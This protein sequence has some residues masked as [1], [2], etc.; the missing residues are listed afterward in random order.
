M[1]KL[2]KNNNFIGQGWKN[3]SK[4]IKFFYLRSR[5][6]FE[7]ISKYF[8]VQVKLINYISRLD[9]NELS[10]IILHNNKNRWMMNRM[11][12]RLKNNLK[13]FLIF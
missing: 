6:R 3:K 7:T 13:L 12:I 4:Y 5:F 10:M 11:I 8:Q 9:T 2:Y 1:K